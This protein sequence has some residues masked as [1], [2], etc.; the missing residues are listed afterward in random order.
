MKVKLK[1]LKVVVEMEGNVYHPCVSSTLYLWGE[2]T[3]TTYGRQV[4][5]RKCFGATKAP[6]FLQGETCR[7][8]DR[9]I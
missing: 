6:T 3:F 1:A 4:W 8:A 7:Y 2:S 9:C 5:K